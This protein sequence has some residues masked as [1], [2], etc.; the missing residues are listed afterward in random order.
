MSSHHDKYD[1]L[2]K[3]IVIGDSGVG[4]SSLLTQFTDHVFSNVYISTIGVDFKIRTFTVNGKRVKLQIWDTAGQERFHTITTSY[5]RGVHG[6]LIVYDVTD[7]RTFTN[8]TT[9]QRELERFAPPNV[10]RILIGNKNDLEKE[11]Q[12]TCATAQS[13]A[14]QYEMDWIETSA[15]NSDH[16][17]HIFERIVQ[18]ML[19]RY[20]YHHL[21]IQSNNVSSSNSGCGNEGVEMDTTQLLNKNDTHLQLCGKCCR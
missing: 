7:V 10:Y 6:V 20:T 9:W 16:V 21:T 13:L 8:L 18:T 11:R 19:Q 2:F 14:Q 15:R 1:F 4:K 12:V 3:L 17:D 5:Y